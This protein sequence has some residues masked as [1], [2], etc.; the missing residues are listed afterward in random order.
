MAGAPGFCEVE[1]RMGSDQPSRQD[2]VSG[3]EI[4]RILIS[5][6]AQE[7]PAVVARF[8]QYGRV[9]LPNDLRCCGK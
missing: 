5:A 2:D 9:S 8:T 1:A 7:S 4:K 3:F 6:G